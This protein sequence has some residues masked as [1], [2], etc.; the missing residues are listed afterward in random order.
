VPAEM[1]SEQSQTTSG[2]WSEFAA[3]VAAVVAAKAAAACTRAPQICRTILVTRQYRWAAWMV[4]MAVIVGWDY[5]SDAAYRASALTG[6]AL[7]AVALV[8]I[9]AH[10]AVRATRG[11]KRVLKR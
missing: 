4:L 9:G 1:P 3:L 2:S 11:T 8:E 6:L 10:L 7:V 5:G